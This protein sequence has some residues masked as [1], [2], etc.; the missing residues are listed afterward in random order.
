[1]ALIAN[2]EAFVALGAVFCVTTANSN[3]IDRKVSNITKSVIYKMFD[4]YISV[5]Y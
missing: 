2:A 5:P 4:I 3:C 1:M